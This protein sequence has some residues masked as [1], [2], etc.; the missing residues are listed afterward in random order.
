MSIYKVTVVLSFKGDITP[1]TYSVTA[2]DPEEAERLVLADMRIVWAGVN[3]CE[4]TVED[5]P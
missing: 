4:L 5:G 1:Y 3:V 2:A